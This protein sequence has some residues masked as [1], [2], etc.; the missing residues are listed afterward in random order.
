MS[1]SPVLDVKSDK[2]IGIISESWEKDEKNDRNLSFA[3]PISSLIQ[4]FR[5]IKVKNSSLS[6]ELAQIDNNTGRKFESR[7]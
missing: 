1:G 5:E 2:I 6:E 7:T 4:V 3:I